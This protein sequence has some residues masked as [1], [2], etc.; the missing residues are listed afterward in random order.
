MRDDRIYIERIIKY[1]DQIDFDCERF[2][3]DAEIY[4]ED[5][6]YQRSTDMSLQQIGET[7]N[8]LSSELLERYNEVEWDAVIGFRN[9][10]AHRYEWMDRNRIWMIIRDDIP[11]LRRYCNKMFQDIS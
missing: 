9:I 7:V 2:G 10:I 6:S 3:D 11:R 1:C 4:Y 8:K 5:R